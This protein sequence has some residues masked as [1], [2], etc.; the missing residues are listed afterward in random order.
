MEI[1]SSAISC[2][3]ETPWAT[4]RH[5]GILGIDFMRHSLLCNQIDFLPV[6]KTFG[7]YDFLEVSAEFDQKLLYYDVEGYKTV[8]LDSV[9]F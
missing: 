9:L 6:Q 8:R 2:F 7:T 4:F 3:F 1:K 5:I